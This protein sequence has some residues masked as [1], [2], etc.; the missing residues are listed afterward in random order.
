MRPYSFHRPFVGD[1]RQ[2]LLSVIPQILERQPSCMSGS[3]VAIAKDS[4][5]ESLSK[6]RLWQIFRNPEVSRAVGP[7]FRESIEAVS[8][9]PM[10]ADYT[11]VISDEKNTDQRQ[12]YSV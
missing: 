5:F 4:A 3:I 9:K 12:T 6:Q 1:C 8:I 2:Q 7:K 11:G 10:N